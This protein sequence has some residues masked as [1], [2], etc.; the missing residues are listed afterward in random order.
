MFFSPLSPR[1]SVST[2]SFP[3]SAWERADRSS[4]SSGEPDRLFCWIPSRDAREAELRQMR[5]QAELGNEEAVLRL[6]PWPR[7]ANVADIPQYFRETP[8]IRRPSS[9]EEYL[10]ASVWWRR[11][12]TGRCGIEASLAGT[13][14][15]ALTAR[16]FARWPGAGIHCP[17]RQR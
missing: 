5:S 11:R 3:S 17:I 8:A 16:R 2:H 13:A 4:A 14:S 7:I 1:A 6:T 12:R 15:R 9:A 10:P